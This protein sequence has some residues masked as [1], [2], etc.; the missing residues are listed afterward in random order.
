[1]NVSDFKFVFTSH[2]C[3]LHKSAYVFKISKETN[4]RKIHDDILTEIVGYFRYTK[5][6]NIAKLLTRVKY[7]DYKL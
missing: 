5:Y 3:F 6:F 1:M 7:E 4:K 2:V